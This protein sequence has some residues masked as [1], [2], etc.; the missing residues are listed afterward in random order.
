M[1]LGSPL[2]TS[3]LIAKHIPTLTN[4]INDNAVATSSNKEQAKTKSECNHLSENW[5]EEGHLCCKERTDRFRL[6]LIEGVKL[7]LKNFQRKVDYFL[8]VVSRMWEMKVEVNNY[9]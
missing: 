3:I 1:S 7:K 9:N 2:T 8:S 5:L 4:L 6:H